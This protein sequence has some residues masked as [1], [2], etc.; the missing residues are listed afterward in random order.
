M[1]DSDDNLDF[2]EA[3][4]Q[5]DNLIIKNIL[6]F[7]KT[8]KFHN[9]TAK[10]YM[11]AYTIVYKLADDDDETSTNLLNYYT[12]TINNYMKEVCSQLLYEPKDKLLEAFLEHSMKSKILI[13]WMRKVFNYLDK[14]HTQQINTGNLFE[15]ALKS[16]YTLLFHPLMSDIIAAL[17]KLINEHRDGIAVYEMTIIKIIR[18]FKIVGLKDPVL[19]KI[20]DD[21]EWS[22]NSKTKN[23]GVISDWLNNHFLPS[24]ENYI[25]TKAKNEISTMSAPEYI[26]SCLKYLKEEDHR[27]NLFIP[28]SFHN[29]LDNLNNKYLIE[30]NS[31]MLANVS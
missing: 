2:K 5:I 13:H 4:L 15:I 3:I 6:N 29:A 19:E 24:T 1:S 26:K 7:L 21:Y 9:K 8:G 11:I 17:N 30:S 14:F 23:K 12:D 31:A 10:A 28:K 20:G 16:Y 27:K 18:I 25:S 22:G